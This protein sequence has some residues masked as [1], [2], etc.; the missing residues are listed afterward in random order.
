MSSLRELPAAASQAVKVTTG[1]AAEALGELAKA[2]NK[3]AADNAR[4]AGVQTHIK[5][6][7]SKLETTM[8]DLP[9]GFWGKL[10]WLWD[11]PPIK[12]LRI[13]VSMANMG[14]KL[15]ALL[16][17]IATQ[18]NVLA[19]QVTLPMLAPL[20]LGSGM[21]FR[22]M[23][24]NASYI[25]PRMGIMVTLL[26]LLWFANGVVQNTVAYLRRQSAVDDR[27]GGAIITT[28]ECCSLL[29]AAVIVLSMV[30]VNVPALL[31]PAGIALAIAVKDLSHNF[32]AGFFLFVAQPFRV[33]DTV[34]V[35]CAGAL[36]AT[37]GGPVAAPPGGPAGGSSGIDSGG[38][39]F[40]GTCE[41]VDLRYTILR[42]GRRRLHVP[43][44]AFLTREFMVLEDV[45][46]GPE[47][48]QQ[49][50]R[51]LPATQPAAGPLTQQ[52]AASDGR[53]ASPSSMAGLN[54]PH[55]THTQQRQQQQQPQQVGSAG[56]PPHAPAPGGT[57]PGSTALPV[58]WWQPPPG[59]AAGNGAGEAGTTTTTT[60]AT[61]Q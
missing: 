31:L 20:L 30:G 22:S 14:I 37:P 8:S 59:P 42:S 41:K 1:A 29:A 2:A 60:S 54:Q 48:Q 27:L 39:W 49:A 57:A 4:S 56:T 43:N 3:L 55:L 32:L 26:W 61:P 24:T 52:P 12:R 51:G 15:P 10:L 11:L 34:A 35:T 53:A 13:G 6:V 9:E 36:P 16:V 46:L 17:L 47:Q 23:R 33:G 28:A 44:S 40:E 19:S 21:V 5:R 18:V 45:P 7:A 25:F 38:R 58:T 50:G